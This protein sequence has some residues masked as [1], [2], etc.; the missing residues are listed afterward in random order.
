MNWSLLLLLLCP[1]SMV[2]CMGSLFRSPKKQ[3]QVESS[4]HVVP[5]S[6]DELK[7]LQIQMADLMVENHELK[8]QA[9]RQQATPERASV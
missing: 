4:V 1:L 7:A 6:Q 9:L 2:F 3:T 8:T 5:D